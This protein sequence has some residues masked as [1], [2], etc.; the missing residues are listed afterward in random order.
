MGYVF[1]CTGSIQWLRE[2]P[3]NFDVALHMH[4]YFHTQK[5]PQWAVPHYMT[6]SSLKSP[7]STT[8]P[9]P[10]LCRSVHQFVSFQTTYAWQYLPSLLVKILIVFKCKFASSQI[11]N[12]ASH[13]NFKM[14][15]TVL[16]EKSAP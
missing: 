13:I 6:P 16:T 11:I 5:D 8:S 10:Q 7:L 14:F 12:Y 15:V 2:L 9:Y 1:F 4:K 3:Y